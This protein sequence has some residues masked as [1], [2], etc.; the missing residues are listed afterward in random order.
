MKVMQCLYPYSSCML[1]LRS[2][3]HK[4]L[5]FTAFGIVLRGVWSWSCGLGFGSGLR[6]IYA[7]SPQKPSTP[8]DYLVLLFLLHLQALN[9]NIKIGWASP[10]PTLAE[11]APVSKSI[12]LVLVWGRG[13]FHALQYI[14][15][16]NINT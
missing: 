4:R 6:G 2:G 1:G 10:A 13:R 9:P 15:F 7:S 5:H 12:G 11:R 8:L 3:P 16:G 14:A